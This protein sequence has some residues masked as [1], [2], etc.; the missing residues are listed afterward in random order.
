MRWRVV[1]DNSR[2]RP[3]NWCADGFND[4]WL[5][6]YHLQNLFVQWFGL[7]PFLVQVGQCQPVR[8]R[9]LLESRCDRKAVVVDKGDEWQPGL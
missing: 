8:G 2:D 5:F 9:R 1:V 3:S 4:E 7:L 6:I